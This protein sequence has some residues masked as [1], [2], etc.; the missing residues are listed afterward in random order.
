MYCKSEISNFELLVT[1]SSNTE[2]GKRVSVAES[3]LLLKS[4][5]IFQAHTILLYI[6]VKIF[7]DPFVGNTALLIAYWQT[8]YVHPRSIRYA[9]DFSTADRK[10]ALQA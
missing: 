8:V 2:A 5:T 4:R 9:I 1:L 7:Q 3:L 6:L 10:S